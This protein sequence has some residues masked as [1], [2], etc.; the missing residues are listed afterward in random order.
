M[1]F[2]LAARSLDHALEAL[3][4]EEKTRYN[5]EIFSILGMSLNKNTKN[6]KKIV[7]NMLYKHCYFKHS[8]HC[9]LA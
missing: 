4:V 5:D 9:Y 2:I 6:L 7:Q 8:E 1:V 3:T